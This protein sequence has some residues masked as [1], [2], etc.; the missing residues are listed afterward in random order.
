MG[1]H[2]GRATPPRPPRR[3]WRPWLAV[4]VGALALALG[5]AG[6]GGGGGKGEEVASLSDKATAT[7]SA[8]SS[9]ERR[10]AFARCMRQHG[11][12]LA[13]PNPNQPDWGPEPEGPKPA[14]WDAAFQA[15]RQLLPPSD[16]PQNAPPSPQELA[17]LRAF[18][19]CM[20]A[21][22]I[23]MSDPDPTTGNMTT[24]HGTRDQF[25]ND[26]AIKA[27]EAACRDKLPAR[28]KHQKR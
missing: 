11:V 23:N 8:G 10:V 28:D 1:G 18:A 13:D 3:R 25:L 14:G 20:R 19:V 26:P 16:L 9:Q 7:T 17:Q 5:V 27:A 12:Q 2:G 6:C 4:L 21:H 15:C 24:G 22:G